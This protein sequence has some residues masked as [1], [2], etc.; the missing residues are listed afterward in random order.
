MNSEELCERLLG[1][2]QNCLELVMQLPKTKYNLEYGSQLI[3][4]SAS[5]G[6]NYIEAVEGASRKDFVYKL[7]VCRKECKESIHWLRLIKF[8]NKEVGQTAEDCDKLIA[9]ACG[10]IK[11]FTSSILTSEKNQKNH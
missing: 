9:E 5:P 7:K 11:I 2:A 4:C 1:F 3:R 6:A 10:F 8:A